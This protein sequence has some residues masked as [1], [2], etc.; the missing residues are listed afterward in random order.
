MN[1]LL[2][3]GWGL[4]AHSLQ[5][6][7]DA[8]Q[9]GAS[10]VHCAALDLGFFGEP[11]IPTIADERPWILVGH[12]YGFYYL[13]Q[14]ARQHWSHINIVGWV[15][16]CGFT[17]FM[18][19]PA[20][21]KKP[22]TPRRAL[23]AMRARLQTDPQAT[24]QDF[25]QRCGLANDLTV[26][27]HYE[28]S[29]LS[30]H[31]ALLQNAQTTLPMQPLLALAGERDEIVSPELSRVCFPPSPTVQVQW[32]DATHALPRTHATACAQVI[33]AWSTTL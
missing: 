7:A 2:A 32:F 11:L 21:P 24:L 8:L 15:S 10:P 19:N 23:D 9:Q 25:Y 30:T 13:L 16:V 5:P 3:P 27:Y 33:Q 20:E 31:L 6:L 17:H 14:H 26:P 18:R 4:P 22:G 1:Y 12:S 28:L 29:A